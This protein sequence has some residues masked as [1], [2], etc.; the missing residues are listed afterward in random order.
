MT[1]IRR[2]VYVLLVVAIGA[3]AAGAQAPAQGRLTLSMAPLD[4]SEVA[5]LKNPLPSGAEAVAKGKRLYDQFCI[6]CH[7]EDGKSQFQA[8]AAATD[9]TEPT[10]YESGTSDGEV[11]RS[12]RDG[13]GVSM[14]PF[15]GQIKTETEVWELVL[16]VKSLWR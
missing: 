6:Q 10:L 7:G 12:I 14:P 15:R 1:A 11:F 5:K 8:V 13:A 3:V 9:L 16:Y 2:G 4:S